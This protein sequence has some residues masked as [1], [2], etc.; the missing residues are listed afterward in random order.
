MRKSDEE[1]FEFVK[2]FVICLR[3]IWLVIVVMFLSLFL[4]A[5]FISFVEAMPPGRAIYFTFITALAVC[6]GDVTPATVTGKITSVFVGFVGMVLFGIIV[7]ISTRAVLV[8][9]HSSELEDSEN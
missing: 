5:V 6:Y 2:Q 9:M 7:G 1:F 8:I 4:T 3:H